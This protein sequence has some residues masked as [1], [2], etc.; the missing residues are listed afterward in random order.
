[1]SA[2]VRPIS[3]YHSYFCNSRISSFRP[4]VIP[5]EDNIVYI[6][7][8]PVFFYKAFKLVFIK[9]CKRIQEMKGVMP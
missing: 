4:E 1:M 8:K 3:I 2:M 7:C 9:I 6:H 5:A